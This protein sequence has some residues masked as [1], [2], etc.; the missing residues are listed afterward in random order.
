MSEETNKPYKM[1]LTK[2]KL[3]EQ[4]QYVYETDIGDFKRKIT[5]YLNRFAQGQKDQDLKKKIQA[6]KDSVL[7]REISTENQ[8]KN[9]DLL[10]FDL[11]EKLKSL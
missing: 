8:M 6:L 1:D 10:R 7:Y 11:L 3:I 9:I 5:L 4:I 2:E